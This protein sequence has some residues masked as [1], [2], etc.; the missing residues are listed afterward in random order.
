FVYALCQVKLGND[1]AFG[2]FEQLT[3]DY[4][5]TDVAVRS[6]SL[7]DARER[8][9]RAKN[10]TGSSQSINTGL[11]YSSFGSTDPLSCLIIIPRN[12]NVNL[13]KASIS[14]LNNK[15]FSL[16]NIQLGPTLTTLEKYL[17][18]VEN[19]ESQSKTKFY[20][21]FITRQNDYFAS[22]GLFE[23]VVVL[24]NA[25]NLKILASDLDWQ[26][27]LQWIEENEP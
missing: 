6:K 18:T 4:P 27:Y 15:E 13:V 11:K 24:I 7:L 19:F 3:I 9:T 21:D 25:D 5:N 1:K 26:A 10:D 17:I 12:S 14:D 20:K 2:I 16:E 22:K 8:I 23:Y